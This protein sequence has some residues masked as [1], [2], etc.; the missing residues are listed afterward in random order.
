[1]GS[2]DFGGGDASICGTPILDAF[3]WCGGVGISLTNMDTSFAGGVKSIV[4]IS[5]SA[6]MQ[7]GNWEPS[8]DCFVCTA[9][10]GTNTPLAHDLGTF[11][12]LVSLNINFIWPG[13]VL[14]TKEPFNRDKRS[15]GGPTQ[16]AQYPSQKQH[17][18]WTGMTPACSL[19]EEEKR[20]RR[21]HCYAGSEYSDWK[22]TQM[23]LVKATTWIMMQ[24]AKMSRQE[25]PVMGCGKSSSY[26]QNWVS[27]AMLPQASLHGRAHAGL[28]IW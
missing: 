16:A 27:E 12:L 20:G 1:M 18:C 14:F 24:Q 23:Q 11:G 26:S 28:K 2:F 9:C 17:Q 3:G 4:P 25:T 10:T 22:R 8:T 6:L 19:E 7:D 13:L 5:E 15:K 21:C